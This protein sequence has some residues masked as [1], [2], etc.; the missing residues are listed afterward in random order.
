LFSITSQVRSA[1]FCVLVFAVLANDLAR[2][3]AML[4]ARP[5]L[6]NMAMSYD[7]ERRPIHFA[8][9]GRL[10]KMTA[11]LM[12]QGAD[13]RAGVHPHR[14]ATTA[15]TLARERGYAELVAIIEQ[16][17]QR[18]GGT[19]DPE[20]DKEIFGDE[21]A[22]AAVVAGN[23][24]WL[25]ARH[26]EGK[27]ANPIRWRDGGLLTVAVEHN[28]PEILKLLL[29]FGFDPD[30]RVASGE[31]DWT[32]YSQGFPLWQAAALGRR[33][34]AEI[35]LQRGA[36][37]N[38]EVDSSGSAV[39]SAYSHKQFDM[40]EL[41]RSHGG[42]VGADTAAIYRQTGLIRQMLR[43]DHRREFAEGLLRFAASGG[44]PD[45]VRMVLERIDWPRDDPRWFRPLT[46]PRYFWHQIPWLYAGNRDFDRATYLICFRLILE[47]CDP[48]VVGSFGRTAH[49]RSRRWATGLP[50]TKPW[51]LRECCWMPARGWM[52][53][54]NCCRARRWGGPAGGVAWE[55]RKSCWNAGP[56][57]S[58]AIPNL[59][60]GRRR[61]RRRWG[62]RRL[63]RCCG[64]PNQCR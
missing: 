34:M 25:L 33:E 49:T 46:E 12:R 32:A 63:L 61:G 17:E 43:D 56:I 59:G 27:F 58:N 62:I 53:A 39:Y 35:L 10:P 31:G 7:D 45:I 5:E 16:E 22:R 21:A 19:A 14:Q 3:E 55:S 47:R 8:V 1:I 41:L 18:R 40:V 51:S 24:E 44:D 36:N 26:A 50:T 64:K 54:T 38:A 11:L 60:R 57:R 48:N 4:K 15:W 28:R 2:V 13:A 23:V 37:P 52:F 6:A 30:E 42:V 20:E 29:D 9:M